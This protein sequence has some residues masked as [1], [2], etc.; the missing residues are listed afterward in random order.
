MNKFDRIGILPDIRRKKTDY[1][2]VRE[3][4]IDP[5]T[6]LAVFSGIGIAGISMGA[7]VGTYVFFG[8]VTL[9]GLIAIVESNR[10][11]KVLTTRSNKLIDV[12]IFG[13]SVYATASLGVTVSAALVF[14][15]LGYSLVYA[16]YLR[17][18]LK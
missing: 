9:V 8:T 1:S 10:S 12:M 11:L 14:A 2:E 4:I 7:T 5:L 18:G 6:G 17:E 3:T 15:G 16:P 13:A